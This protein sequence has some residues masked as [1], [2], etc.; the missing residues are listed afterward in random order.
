MKRT[1]LTLTLIVVFTVLFVT[2]TNKT[3]TEEVE[4]SSK[5]LGTSVL[6][7][8]EVLVVGGQHPVN[9]HTDRIKNIDLLK[10]EE[11]AVL[12]I[13]TNVLGGRTYEIRK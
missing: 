13:R 8:T 1:I 10:S 3:V 11:T 12:L 2:L 7:G 9:I 5:Q 6:T 4:I